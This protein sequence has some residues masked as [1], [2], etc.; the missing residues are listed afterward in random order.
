MKIILE[1]RC[2]TAKLD[3]YVLRRECMRIIYYF[4]I[5]LFNCHFASKTKCTN[6]PSMS[7]KSSTELMLYV[8]LTMP[9]LNK[10]YLLFIIIYLL[11]D[12]T[13]GI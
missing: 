13:S 2:V 1:T 5:Q 10:A 9:T 4:V 3:I 12:F 7:V 6:G 11:S 8:V